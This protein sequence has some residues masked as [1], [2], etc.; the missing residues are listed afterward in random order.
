MTRRKPQEQLQTSLIASRSRRCAAGIT[1]HA[2]DRG[3]PERIRFA[4]AWSTA[5]DGLGTIWAAALVLVVWP[6]PN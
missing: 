1:L 5:L 2:R 3:D 6:A 4:K